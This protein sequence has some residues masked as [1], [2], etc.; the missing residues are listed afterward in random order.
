[1]NDNL[2]PH[3]DPGAVLTFIAVVGACFVLG[4]LAGWA[5]L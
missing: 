5:F 2:P 1:M 4:V 3:A